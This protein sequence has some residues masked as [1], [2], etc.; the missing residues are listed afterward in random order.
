MHIS[1]T[2][3]MFHSAGLYLMAFALMTSFFVTGCTPQ[4]QPQP[5]PP[6]VTCSLPTAKSLSIA[7]DMTKDDLA[8]ETCAY[9]FEAYFGNLLTIAAGAPEIENKKRFSDF[10]IWCSDTGLLTRVQAQKY[11]NQYFSQTFMALP[12]DYNICSICADKGP[13][14]QKMKKELAMKEQELLKACADK[15]GYYQVN[16]QYDEMSFLLEATCRA[17]AH[18]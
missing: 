13:L 12:D 3:K 17:C 4:H 6:R 7:I 5:Y 1:I 14:M 15:T 10:L 11:Y 18:E 2:N 8:N 9:R 16:E